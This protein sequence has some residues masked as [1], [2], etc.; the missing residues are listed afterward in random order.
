M[1]HLCKDM[2]AKA[3]LNT[4]GPQGDRVPDEAKCAYEQE[5]DCM[6]PLRAAARKVS[7]SDLS[8][9]V[10]EFLGCSGPFDAYCRS[11]KGVEEAPP[12]VRRFV[13]MARE[14]GW[15]HINEVPLQ[16]LEKVR[17][18]GV[19]P[20]FQGAHYLLD[21]GQDTDAV[22]LELVLRLASHAGECR[23]TVVGDVDQAIYGFRGANTRL[24]EALKAKQ[25]DELA[26][27]LPRDDAL[28]PSVRRA[29]GVVCV[30]LTAVSYTHLTL[31][32]ILL[33]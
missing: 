30:P 12:A 1:R 29:G 27:L 7:H 32:T 11:G 23:L 21:E 6:E 5:W 20:A 3:G 28:P 17:R 10:S 33:V 31:P 26:A 9:A 22:Q 15:L 13:A 14:K 19:P 4:A 8:A 24:M 25:F 16:A 2:C 18:E